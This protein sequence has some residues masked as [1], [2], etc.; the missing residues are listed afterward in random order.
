MI[1]TKMHAEALAHERGERDD[2]DGFM[3]VRDVHDHLQE[4]TSERDPTP[5]TKVGDDADDGAV[6]GKGF[7]DR[8]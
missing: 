7:S 3:M 4:E 2:I 5:E 8:P 1:V 6:E